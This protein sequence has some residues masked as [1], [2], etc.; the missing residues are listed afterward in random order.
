MYQ[1]TATQL[2]QT[3]AWAPRP[4]EQQKARQRDGGY[5]QAVK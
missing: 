2:F 1:D 3:N 5:G 4:A